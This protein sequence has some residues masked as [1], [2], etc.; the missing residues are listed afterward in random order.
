MRGKQ[1]LP[2]KTASDELLEELSARGIS[3]GDGDVGATALLRRS[4]TGAITARL[5]RLA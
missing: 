5:D 4:T 3:I 2:E 1:A